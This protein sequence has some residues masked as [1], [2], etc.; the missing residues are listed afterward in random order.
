MNAHA[1]I[2]RA[3]DNYRDKVVALSHQIHEQ[4]ELKFQEH[5]AA[6]LLSGAAR[7]LGLPVETGVGGLATAFRAEF[8][9]DRGPTVAILA[10]Y[11][12]LP[13]GHSCGHN[14]IACAAL[15]RSSG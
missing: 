4:P 5:F 7:E 9:N 14:L 15:S 3:I 12:A 2:G 13:N 6:G 11:D 8:G 1:E 10:E